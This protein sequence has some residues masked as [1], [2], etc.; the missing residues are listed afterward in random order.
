MYPEIIAGEIAG[1]G[2]P[3]GVDYATKGGKAS[4]INVRWGAIAG[5]AAGAI[6]GV[7]LAGEEFGWWTPR[8]TTDQKAGLFAFTITSLGMGAYMIA[9][10]RGVLPLRLKKASEVGYRKQQPLPRE[11]VVESY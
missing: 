5:I 8:L 9:K 7:I 2:L 4:R 3:I 1:F 6:G 10:D 11:I